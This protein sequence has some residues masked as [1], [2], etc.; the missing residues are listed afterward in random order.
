MKNKI[1]VFV[2][3]AAF[4]AGFLLSTPLFQVKN[5]ILEGYQQDNK[6]NI[7]IMGDNIFLL[8]S[9]EETAEKL[10]EDPY[11][12]EISASRH[13]PDTVVMEISYNRPEAALKIGG[14]YTVINRYSYIIAENLD[15]NI[16]D[17]PV[18]KGTSYRFRGRELILPEDAEKIVK[19][20]PLL[21][22]DLKYSIDTISFSGTDIEMQ[23]AHDCL[24]YLGSSDEINY[25]FSLLNS[26]WQRDDILFSRLKYIDLSA[27]DRPV[28]REE[29]KE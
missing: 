1:L 2:I 4:F 27:P 21:E 5:V 24:I 8:E 9:L 25:K 22:M 29:K 16:K 12:E 14:E 23:T 19:T 10:K 17:V 6:R 15:E 3:I 26:L 20:L 28:I 11:I 13:L 7:A 18:L